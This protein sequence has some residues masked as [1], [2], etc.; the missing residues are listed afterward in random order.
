MTLVDRPAI[1]RRARSHLD[2]CALFGRRAWL[3]GRGRPASAGGRVRRQSDV[4]ADRR[5]ADHPRGDHGRVGD[6]RGRRHR[7]PGA[8]RRADHPRES[9]VRDD[10]CAAHHVDVHVPCGNRT[11]RLSAAAG[12]LR[13]GAPERHPAR[14]A[15][16]GGDH[17]VATGD[18]RKPGRSGYR[19]D[20][21]AIRRKGHDAVGSAADPDGLRAGHAR[22]RDGRGD[23]LDVRR[24]GPGERP[25]VPG[26]PRRQ[27]RS[28]RRRRPPSGR[29]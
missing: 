6:G 29:R 16:G 13:N 19:R 22:R 3:V 8:H 23:R 10:R 12:D 9:E 24:Q 25:G 17:R 7:F 15:D 5:D 26:A 2:G 14:A 28:R 11:H 18:H 4:A 27:A 21:R 20:D 1:R